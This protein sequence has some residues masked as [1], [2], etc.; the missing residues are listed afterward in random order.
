MMKT[1]I[2]RQWRQT[3]Y[4]I[5]NNCF[6]NFIRPLYVISPGLNRIFLNNS[7]WTKQSSGHD[8]RFLLFFVFEVISN[9]ENFRFCTSNGFRL[10]NIALSFKLHVLFI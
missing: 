9:V 7:N 2:H 10:K 5:I 8:F 4:S 6:F 1:I 3:Y